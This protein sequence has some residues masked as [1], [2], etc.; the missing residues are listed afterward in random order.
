MRV[1]QDRSISIRQAFSDT[2]VTMLVAVVPCG[3]HVSV[4]QN[5]RATAHSRA[6]APLLDLARLS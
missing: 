4:L 6:G 3:R 1:M 5:G 2:K